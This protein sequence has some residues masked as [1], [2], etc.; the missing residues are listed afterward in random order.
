VA[1]TLDQGETRCALRLDGEVD[2]STAPELKDILLN[3]LSTGRELRVDL[4]GADSMD[5]SAFQLLWA[6]KREAKAMGSMFSIE[7][8]FPEKL[9]ASLDEAALEETPADRN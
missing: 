3:A 4:T 8:Q 2:I 1:L 6:A 5:L 7:G 9:A